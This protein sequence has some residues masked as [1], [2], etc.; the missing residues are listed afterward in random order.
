[1]RWFVERIHFFSK[2]QLLPGR[3]PMV[4]ELFLKGIDWKDF[5]GVVVV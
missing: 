5:E 4:K 1:M 2:K 3:I